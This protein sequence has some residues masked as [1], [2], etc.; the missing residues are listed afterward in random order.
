MIKL[1]K[2]IKRF[3]IIGIIV[4]S[5]LGIVLFFVNNVEIEN[6]EEIE[7]ESEISEEDSM[8]INVVG[9]VLNIETL[10]LEKRTFLINQKD[11]SNDMYKTILNELIQ[12]DNDEKKLTVNE[13]IELNID[14]CSEEL[15]VLSIRFNN[16]IQCFEILDENN[17]KYVIEM[18]SKTMKEINEV[19]SIRFF[20]NDI[21]YVPAV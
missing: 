17:R 19:Q 16:D 2:K 3:I 5:I 12:K 13:I 7:P 8:K 18:I 21:E 6:V 15:G 14:S 4:F 1:D 9:Y 20:F 10:E 11:I